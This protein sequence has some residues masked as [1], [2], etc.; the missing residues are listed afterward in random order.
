MPFCLSKQ[1]SAMLWIEIHVIK[2]QNH[3]S[4]LCTLCQLLRCIDQVY[5]DNSKGGTYYNTGFG[6]LPVINPIKILLSS[7]PSRFKYLR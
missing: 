3:L 1:S 2:M 6:Y 7:M 4:I 5:L